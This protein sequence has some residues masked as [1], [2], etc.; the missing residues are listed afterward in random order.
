MI[1]S[2]FTGITGVRSHQARINVIGNNVA[3]IN[4]T[5]F[6]AGRVNFADVMSRTL[7]EAGPASGQVAA[8]N[9]LQSG[10]GV[11]VSS[12]DS[13]LT[14]GTLQNTGVETD[15]AI[16]GDG[17]FILGTGQDR[18][19]TRDGTFS[20]DAT[21][22]LYDP[23]TGLV[24]QGNV[25]NADGSFNAQIEDLI[26]PLDRQ[27]EA[28]A[29]TKVNLSGNIDASATGKGDHVWT[30]KTQFGL[31]ARLVTGPNP[32]FPLDLSNLQSAGLKV[33]VE[34][35]GNLSEST[36][37]IP[38]KVF[39]DREE[40]IAELNGLINANGVLKNKVFFKDNDLG[41]VILRTV[42]GGSN[43]TVSV[44][45]ADPNNNV[46][47]LL[48]FAAN[49]QEDGQKSEDSTLINDL[50]NVGKGMQDGDIIRFKGFKPNGERFDG[51]FTFNKDTGATLGDLFTSVANAY[52]GVTAGVD[53][54]TGLMVLTDQ[55]T[56]DSVA[57][58]QITYALLVDPY[59][60]EDAP[61][62]FGDDPPAEFSTNTQVFDEK[63][64]SHSL[65]V[66]FTRS[67][68]DN[69]WS[70]VAMLDGLTPDAGNNGRAVFNEDGTLRTFESSD[71]EPLRF[72]PDRGSGELTIEL[73]AESD[74]GLQGMTQFA[75]PSSVS[76]YRVDGRP[77]GNLLSLNIETNGNITGLFS[78]GS[79][80]KL[81]RVM[82]ATFG[83]P[84]GLR[85]DGE[86]LFAESE[87]SGEAVTGA[88]ESTVQGS[89]HSR[90]IELSNVDLAEE[91]TNMILSQRGFQASARSITTSDELLTELVNLKR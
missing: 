17:M 34:E 73:A 13:I 18:F 59:L 90:S 69:E 5:A 3:N 7:S 25:A 27:S 71:G 24:V 14:Q 89:V 44:D 55:T 85:R 16:E 57:G 12:I 31:P 42:K 43:V 64:E 40:M 11:K 88:A 77:A 70:W 8:T 22:R 21:G 81:G 28:K 45:N 6:K 75:S 9:P 67:V 10:L 37:N 83:N 79:A 1:D 19:Y 36:L 41:E 33:S 30:S 60:L 58:V 52:G 4:T 29:S 68:I 66:T 35:N 76:V 26:V 80:E 38:T 78:N 61:G 20:F 54:N 82:L 87:A 74:D 46:A 15:L 86:N 65:T 63:G 23:G 32:A 39:A 2:I 51:R 50:A 56:G 47:G 49:T 72:E 62:I 53:E 91:F 48:G 84:G